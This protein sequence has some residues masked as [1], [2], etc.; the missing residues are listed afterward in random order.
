M[1]LRSRARRLQHATGW[2]YQRAL[3]RLRALGASPASLAGRARWPLARADAYLVDPALDDEWRAV[4]A[5]AA[6][7]DEARCALCGA[8]FFAGDEERR[9]RTDA[10][11]R[12][13]VAHPRAPVD[14]VEALPSPTRDDLIRDV[15]EEL[16]VTAAARGVLLIARDGRQL[17]H[18][19]APGEPEPRLMFHAWVVHAQAVDVHLPEV[20]EIGDGEQLFSAPVG[21]LALLVVRFDERTSLGLVRLR[22]R[23]AIEVLE[24]LLVEPA[25]GRPPPP[26]SGGP[27]GAPAEAVLDV[28][29]L[30]RPKPKPKPKP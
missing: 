2:S 21:K 24:R 9:A 19:V 5:R 10:C 25:G 29:A 14:V 20:F 23:H 3:E 1:S 7:V 26:V 12:C 6:T 30:A 16:C 8:V 15:C 13:R 11:P 28:R 27:G 18:V 4:A 22:A 17:A